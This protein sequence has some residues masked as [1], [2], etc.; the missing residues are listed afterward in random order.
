M[1]TQDRLLS[2]LEYDQYTGVFTWKQTLGPRAIKGRPAGNDDGQG[3]LRIRVDGIVY[4]AHRLAWLA[5][6]GGFPPEHIDHI[7]HIRSDNRICNL[8][9]VTHAENQRNASKSRLNAS[10]HS[11]VCFDS[12]R[13]KWRVEVSVTQPN[14]AARRA[15]VGYFDCLEDACSARKD[16]L[17]RH[18]FHQNHGA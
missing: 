18:G 9:A 2:V 7:N 15:H 11:G 5:I 13:K 12:R 16:A 3:Y 4:R 17:L 8:R 10:G 1:I 14:G 6:H